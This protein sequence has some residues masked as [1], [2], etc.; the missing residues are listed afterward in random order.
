MIFEKF[1]ETASKPLV[2]P[3]KKTDNFVNFVDIDLF[4]SYTF[5]LYVNHI[6]IRTDHLTTTPVLN[7]LEAMESMV[8]TALEAMKS[9]SY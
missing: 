4:K 9:V 1:S 5:S 6:I 7:Q 8:F 2:F 3:F